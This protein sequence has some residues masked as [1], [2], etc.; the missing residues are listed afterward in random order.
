LT[1]LGHLHAQGK[2]LHVYH[3]GMTLHSHG[4]NE[5]GEHDGTHDHENLDELKES[6]GRFLDEEGK[7]GQGSEA[8]GYEG[9]GEL[10]GFKG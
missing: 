6:M 5:A 10:G 4:I 9:D 3:D 1:H 8:A 2:H 7:E